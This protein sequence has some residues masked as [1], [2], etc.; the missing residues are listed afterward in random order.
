MALLHYPIWRH[1]QA[2]RLEQ[3]FGKDLV[4]GQGARQDPGAGVGYPHHLQKPLNRAILAITTVQADKRN[5]YRF[6]RENLRKVT[7]HVDGY[8]IVTALQKRFVYSG[9]AFQGDLPLRGKPPHQHAD[10]FFF[11]FFLCHIKSLFQSSPTIRTSS[12]S[13]IPLSSFTF[14]LMIPASSMKSA[15]RAPPRLTRKL[16]CSSATCAPPTRCP[17]ST[18]SSMRRHVCFPSGFLKN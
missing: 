15:A 6:F 18:A 11:Q 12:S 5:L 7:P 13:I 3:L 9:A 8:R 17:F 1:G 16:L 10:F 14:S 4:H 2:A